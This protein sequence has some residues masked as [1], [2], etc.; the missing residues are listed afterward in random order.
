M[1]TSELLSQNIILKFLRSA[2]ESVMKYVEWL[3][4]HNKMYMQFFPH[5]ND[6]FGEG[7]LDVKHSTLLFVHFGGI[8]FENP[9]WNIED[10]LCK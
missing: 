2:F 8:G 1:K 3:E 4:A 7:R 6:I 10:S 5:T 9:F